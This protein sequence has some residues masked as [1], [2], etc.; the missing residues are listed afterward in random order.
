MIGDEAAADIFTALER[1]PNRDSRV[2]LVAQA[3]KN[4]T[5]RTAFK[6]LDTPVTLALSRYPLTKHVQET[7]FK[8]TA[9]DFYDGERDRIGALTGEVEVIFMN[10]EGQLCEGSFTSLFIEKDGQLLTPALSCGLLA[11]V[12]RQ[13]L[14]ESEDAA[15]AIVNLNDIKTADKIFIGNS[16]RGLMP[17]QFIDFLRH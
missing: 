15:E 7:R 4:Q 11:G 5:E 8:T 2:K 17:A 16:L 3:G 10:T 13:S 12:L 6:A 1:K 9:R 14:I